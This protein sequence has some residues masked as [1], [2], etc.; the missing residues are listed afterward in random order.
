MCIPAAGLSPL[1]PSGLKPGTLRPGPTLLAKAAS[2]LEAGVVGGLAML[3]VLIAFSLLR[4][5]VW[6][7]APNL[8][9]LDV[10]W[11]ISEPFAPGREH[12]D[13]GPKS[14]FT[15]RLQAPSGMVFGAICGAAGRPLQNLCPWSA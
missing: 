3:S 4:G 10:F 7:E 8:L 9:G 2:G 12:G 6:W 14:R 15:A 1:P 5:R 13:A 11:W